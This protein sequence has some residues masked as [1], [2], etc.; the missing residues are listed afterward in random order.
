MAVTTS[1]ARACVIQ[2]GHYPSNEGCKIDAVK[3][4]AFLET[5]VD[6]GVTARAGFQGAQGSQGAQGASGAV[7][8]QGAQG[9]SG[10]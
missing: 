7:G 5:I 9:A 8:A 1:D 10:A 2:A 4:K 6:D 3:L